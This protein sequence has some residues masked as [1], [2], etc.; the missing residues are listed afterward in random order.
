MFQFAVHHPLDTENKSSDIDLL[1]F[2]L[3][4]AKSSPSVLP[5]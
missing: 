3:L 2:P 1:W 4:S 5:V